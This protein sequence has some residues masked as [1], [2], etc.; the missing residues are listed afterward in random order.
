MHKVW[1]CSDLQ[2]VV[3]VYSSLH[4]FW[5][6]H[7]IRVEGPTS[8]YASLC[9]SLHQWMY[10]APAVIQMLWFPVSTLCYSTHKIRS[11]LRTAWLEIAGNLLVATCIH[12]LTATRTS[13]TS[14]RSCSILRR[15]HERKPKLTQ[16]S[17][18]NSKSQWA[19]L[20]KI[21][22]NSMFFGSRKVCVTCRTGFSVLSDLYK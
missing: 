14:R 5:T 17:Y 7:E 12:P 1:S 19:L 6:V 4:L 22:A 15:R 20:S 13:R 10:S 3:F 9:L 11:V 2:V 21:L 18:K 8:K 16:L